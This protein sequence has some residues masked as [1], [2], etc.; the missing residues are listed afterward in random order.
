VLAGPVE[1]AA[2]GNLLLQAIACGEVASIADGRRLVS[3]MQS[4]RRF[5]ARDDPAWAEA[6]TRY[7]E[8]EDAAISREGAGS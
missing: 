2:A 7:L 4:P 8:I 5:D 6:R 3:R 1:A